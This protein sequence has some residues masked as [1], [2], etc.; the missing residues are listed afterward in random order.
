MPVSRLQNITLTAHYR[1]TSARFLRDSL[2]LH[3][4]FLFNKNGKFVF[5]F[6][7]KKTNKQKTKNKTTKKRKKEKT[8]KKQKQKLNKTNNISKKNVNKSR[9]LFAISPKS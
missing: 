1:V 6:P 8:T 7:L 3:E 4:A 5:S 9:L 2:F